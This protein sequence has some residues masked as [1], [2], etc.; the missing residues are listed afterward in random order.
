MGH[1]VFTHSLLLPHYLH[2][3]RSALVTLIDPFWSPLLQLFPALSLHIICSTTLGT[4]QLE[5]WAG[6]CKTTICCR[7]T[8]SRTL[9]EQMYQCITA[10]S[11]STTCVRIATTSNHAHYLPVK[12]PQR[13]DQADTKI[14]SGNLYIHTQCDVTKIACIIRSIHVWSRVSST[15]AETWS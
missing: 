1:V 13:L 8:P 12:G 4:G 2:L 10:R 5:C 3:N 14:S 11:A 9:F 6:A 7:I 15:N